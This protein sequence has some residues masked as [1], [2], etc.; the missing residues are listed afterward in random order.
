MINI[1][2]TL[3]KYIYIGGEREEKDRGERGEEKD[4]GE[5]GKEKDR[6]ERGKERKERRDRRY[7][8]VEKKLER[9]IIIQ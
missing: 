5:R 6:E 3:Y 1:T 9:I 4:R 7:N 8:K 2:T